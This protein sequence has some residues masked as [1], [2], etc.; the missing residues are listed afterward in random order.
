VFVL[1]FADRHYACCVWPT[2]IAQKQTNNKSRTTAMTYVTTAGFDSGDDRNTNIRR[3]S[4]EH[5]F[6]VFF[7]FFFFCFVLFF[8]TPNRRPNSHQCTRITVDAKDEAVP[9][10]VRIHLI[11][12]TNHQSQSSIVSPLPRQRRTKRDK[13]LSSILSTSNAASTGGA[14]MLPPLVFLS[15]FL[16]RFMF[17]FAPSPHTLRSRQAQRHRC[18]RPVRR[19]RCSTG[20]RATRRRRTTALSRRC[21]CLCLFSGSLFVVVFRTVL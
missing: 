8:Q 16:F 20:R 2:T 7:F 5:F 19:R 9:N 11:V 18:R 1:F 6:F 4:L 17:S 21:L 12:M 10:R 15:G 13:K 14:P 3:R